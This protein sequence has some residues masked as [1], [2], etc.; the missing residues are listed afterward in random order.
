[1]RSTVCLSHA[2]WQP[3]YKI[4]FKA[5]QAN[6]FLIENF[7]W[8]FLER[9]I[10]ICKQLDTTW[11]QIM[12]TTKSFYSLKLTLFYAGKRKICTRDSLVFSVNNILLHSGAIPLLPWNF[13]QYIF[14]SPKL[15]CFQK[16]DMYKTKE[17]AWNDSIE[18]QL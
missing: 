7:C 3:A 8:Y 1:M 9:F 12:M 14:H 11:K 15:E 6:Y 5:S 17:D 4:R 13:I 18:I 10:S 2:R 16:H